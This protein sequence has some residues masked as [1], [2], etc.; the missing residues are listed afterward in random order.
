MNKANILDNIYIPHEYRRYVYDETFSFADYC[1]EQFFSG[2][3]LLN[4]VH[5]SA[6]R[7]IIKWRKQIK[8]Q[9]VKQEILDRMRNRA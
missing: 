4:G 7:V 2:K 8:Q 1:S 6:W 9:K 5:N 3:E